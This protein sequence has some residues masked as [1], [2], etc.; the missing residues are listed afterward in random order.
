ML[1]NVTIFSVSCG[2]ASRHIRQNKMVVNQYS[3]GIGEVL[4][5]HIAALEG[6]RVRFRHA[7][8]FGVFDPCRTAIQSDGEDDSILQSAFPKFLPSRAE[9]VLRNLR[10]P[11]KHR[12]TNDSLDEGNQDTIM[13]PDGDRLC[14]DQQGAIL[15]S[16]R[17][18][19][20]PVRRDGRSQAVSFV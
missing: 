14:T 8:A 16:I 6:S 17:F 2:D 13:R 15:F 10:K 3:R 7:V 9:S 1:P 20:V 4:K 11:Q 19:T 12:N 5:R 18:R